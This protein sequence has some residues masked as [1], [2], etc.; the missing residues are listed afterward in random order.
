M[1]TQEYPQLLAQL[2]RQLPDNTFGLKRGEINL[3]AVV[4]ETQGCTPEQ[5]AEATAL[6]PQQVSEALI[7]LSDGCHPETGTEIHTPLGLVERFC[8]RQDPSRD[9]FVVPDVDQCFLCFPLEIALSNVLE[10]Y[11]NTTAFS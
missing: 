8:D 1:H 7:K 5:L 4:I 3:L 9:R 6:S 11:E 2:L 10:Y